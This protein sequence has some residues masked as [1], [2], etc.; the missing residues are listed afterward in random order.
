MGLSV[1][2]FSGP[3]NILEVK[4]STVLILFAL[5]FKHEPERIIDEISFSY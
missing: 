1:S 3:N 2:L 4:S 5:G